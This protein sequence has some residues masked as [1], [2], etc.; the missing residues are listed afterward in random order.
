MEQ[1]DCLN[2]CGDDPRMNPRNPGNKVKPCAQWV[3]DQAVKAERERVIE[4]ADHLC[5]I[6]QEHGTVC[7]PP[8]DI[9]DLRRLIKGLP[10]SGHPMLV[11]IGKGGEQG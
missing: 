2:E 11:E 1:C 4:L 3:R 10:T 8:Q 6:A 9:D 7:V 5:R